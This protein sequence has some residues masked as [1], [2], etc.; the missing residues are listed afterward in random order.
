MRLK[1]G[2]NVVRTPT[3]AKSVWKKAII[4][5][6]FEKVAF[7][8]GGQVSIQAF[9]YQLLH[10]PSSRSSRHEHFVRLGC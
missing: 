9:E 8:S 1:D 2:I 3:V 7:R 10:L 4:K 5:M 6:S